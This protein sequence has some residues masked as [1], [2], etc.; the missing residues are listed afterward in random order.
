MMSL[1]LGMISLGDVGDGDEQWTDHSVV[2]GAVCPSMT[3]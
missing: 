2:H 1:G 3:K